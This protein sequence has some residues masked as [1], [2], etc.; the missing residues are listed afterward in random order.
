MVTVTSDP[1]SVVTV[2]P[3]DNIEDITLSPTTWYLRISVSAGR[4]LNKLDIVPAGSALKAASVGAKTVNGP[5]PSRVLAR[6]QVSMAISSIVWS[7]EFE[8]IS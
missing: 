5:G 1:S 4:L 2:W 3:L 6:P 7:A 8:I